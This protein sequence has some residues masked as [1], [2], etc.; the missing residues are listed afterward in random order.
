M[1][2]GSI[3]SVAGTRWKMIR[4]LFENDSANQRD[5]AYLYGHYLRAKSMQYLCKEYAAHIKRS[6]AKFIPSEASKSG[7]RQ[8]S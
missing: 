5:L 4:D 1:G 7:P 2:G 8:K 6:K 3:T